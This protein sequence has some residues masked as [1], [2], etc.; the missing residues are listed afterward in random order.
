M[1]AERPLGAGAAFLRANTMRLDPIHVRILEILE[2][3]G[4]ATV[5]S[6]AREVGLTDN[7]VRYRIRKL[8]TSGVVRRISVQV[9]PSRLGHQATALVLLKLAP[10]TDLAKWRTVKAVAMLCATRGAY[11]AVA[12]IVE[13]DPASLERFLAELRRDATL[14][15]IIVLEV[16]PH[17]NLP[18]APSACTAGERPPA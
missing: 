18:V 5:S 3:D 16:E 10:G 6:I 12:L 2:R 13:K 17:D 4:R 7:A 11:Q 9:D 15:E 8:R 1:D 14:H